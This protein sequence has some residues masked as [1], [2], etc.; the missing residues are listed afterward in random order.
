VLCDVSRWEKD[1]RN[2]RDLACVIL[3][4]TDPTHVQRLV[5]ALDPF[6]AFLHCDVKTPAHVF[7]EMVS[8][9]PSR[10]V[11][12]PR[13]NTGWA[14]WENVAAELEGYR[15]ALSRTN[16]THIATLTG[17]DYPLA[18]APEIRGFLAAQRGRSIALYHSLPYSNW[19]RTGGL[20]RLRYRHWVKAKRMLR[21]PIRRKLPGGI[22]FSGGSQVKILARDHAQA[23]VD[24]AANRPD[25]VSFWK[26]TWI[27]DETFVGSILRTPSLVPSWE[28]EHVAKDL[29][30]IAWPEGRSKS[31]PWLTARDFD[32]LAA[33][34]NDDR[35]GVA[36]L[37]ARKFSTSADSTILDLI[38]D[39]LR[40]TTKPSA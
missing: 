3:A 30:F 39:S 8:N 34:K 11:I 10:C 29:W 38:D 12:L 37:F 6:P 17:S 4:H 18:S 15:Q 19:G 40:S 28:Y 21:L 36:K 2:S 23:V 26:R 27:A 13:L 5:E 1:N 33:A 9:L 31:P 32:S 16:A 24:A 22:S 14:R 35:D 7:S 25:L 20:D